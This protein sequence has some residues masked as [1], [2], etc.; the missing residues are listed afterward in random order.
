MS[1]P[2][3]NAYIKAAKDPE[4]LAKLLEEVDHDDSY[5][6]R[7][8]KKATEAVKPWENEWKNKYHGGKNLNVAIP[9]CVKQNCVKQ[10]CVKRR[11]YVKQKNTIK[12]DYV[13][14]N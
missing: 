12:N 13:F 10:N 7:L 9:D 11:S 2:D 14:H 6:T 8:R 5:D 1:K 3:V 4:K